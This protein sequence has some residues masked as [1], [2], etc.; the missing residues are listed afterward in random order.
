MIKKKLSEN[1][2]IIFAL[3]KNEAFYQTQGLNFA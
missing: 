3:I 2:H 1:Q